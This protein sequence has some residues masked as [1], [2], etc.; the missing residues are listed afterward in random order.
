MTDSTKADLSKLI[1]WALAVVLAAGSA[2]ATLRYSEDRIDKLEAW[3]VAHA[4]GQHA[5]T[6]RDV[7]LLRA[8]MNA[9]ERDR[10]EQAADLKAIGE[11]LRLLTRTVDALC[12]ASPRCKPGD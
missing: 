1:P 8:N 10:L 7:A 3:Q 11:Q 6:T 9:I 4:T 2:I 12:A 5:D